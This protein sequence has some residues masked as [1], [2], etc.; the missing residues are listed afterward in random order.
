MARKIGAI[1]GLLLSASPAFAEDQNAC[2]DKI[3]NSAIKTGV[4]VGY[5]M[6]GRTPVVMVNEHMWDR[7]DFMVKSNIAE[8]FD[9]A[10]A[11]PGNALV[12]V[13]Y[14]SNMSGKVLHV[15]DGLKLTA[16]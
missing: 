13:E 9:C 1:L 10:V 11:G 12:G 16:Q 4:I 7:L 3:Q 5:K 6:Q 14:I 8:T 2:Q 15:W